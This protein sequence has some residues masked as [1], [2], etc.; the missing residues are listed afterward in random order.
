MAPVEHPASKERITA[1][2]EL[3]D[4]R[5]NLDRPLNREWRTA[6]TEELLSIA[7]RLQTRVKFLQEWKDAC[8]QTIQRERAGHEPATALSR[9]PFCDRPADSEGGILHSA[10]CDGL[11]DAGLT[12]LQ[13]HVLVSRAAQPQP[14]EQKDEQGR[15]MTYWGGLAQPPPSDYQDETITSLCDRLLKIN[16]ICHDRTLRREERLR[17]V[18]EWSAGFMHPPGSGPTKGSAP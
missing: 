4:D 10:E 12:K 13:H 5:H 15:P 3:F 6:H 18:E 16:N 14:A 11:K 8:E 2:R 9:C 7:E 17:Q 1:L